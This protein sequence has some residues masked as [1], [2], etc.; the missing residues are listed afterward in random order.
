MQT[1]SKNR[2]VQSWQRPDHNLAVAT[3]A[4]MAFL[5]IAGMTAWLLNEQP[6]PADA[7]P[8]AAHSTTADK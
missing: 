7:A 5:L 2:S 8:A 4:L 3:I 6:S 1:R